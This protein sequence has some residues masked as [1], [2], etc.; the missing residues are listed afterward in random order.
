M[1]E[2]AYSTSPADRAAPMVSVIIPAYGVNEYLAEAV[3]SVLAQTYTGYEIFV[4]ND[5][6]PPDETAE[7][8]A[9]LSRYG[10]RVRYLERENGGQAAARNSA[11]QLSTA[12]YVA[13]LDGDDYWHPTL[14]EREMGVLEQDPGLALIYANAWLF[15][16][17]PWVGRTYMDT[18]SDSVG[19]VTLASLLARRCNVT[20]STIIARRSDVIDAGWFDESL[21]Y[22]E[23]YELWL[24]MTHRGA[25]MTYLREPLA[26]RR[27]RHTSLSANSL[28]LEG[29]VVEVLE[30]F[31]RERELTGSARAAW[32]EALSRARSRY[33][34]SA[35]KLSLSSGRPGSAAEALRVVR[36]DDASWKL[37]AAGIALRAVPGVVSVAYRCWSW[38]LDARLRRDTAHAARR[39]ASM[40][41]PRPADAAVAVAADVEK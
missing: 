5:G 6:T 33:G 25:R 10:D 19:P 23:D 34:L 14:L 39:V 2:S 27:L 28:K 40:Q 32:R 31:G 16:D 37:R 18:G 35:A 24:R 8:K 20:M 4:V 22:V 41:R 26:Y 36:L 11:M 3:D 9:I 7:M 13:F 29:A 1:S 21:R 30:S 17:G 15:G 12:P 38:L